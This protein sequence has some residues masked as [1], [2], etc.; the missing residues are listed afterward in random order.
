MTFA[1]TLGRAVRVEGVG[2]HMGARAS[3]ELR[4]H[5][6]PGIRFQRDGTT[7]SATLANVVDTRLA[8]TLGVGGVRVA[9]VEHLCAALVGAGI[10]AVEVAVD[11]PELPVLDGSALPWLEAIDGAGTADTDAPLSPFVV[12]QAVIV[13]RDGGWAR[14]DPAPAFDLDVT[15]EFGHPRIGAQ[16][17]TGRAAG[18]V[19]R[20]E[21]APART[22]GFLRDADALR[23]AG[24]ARGA[25]LE[26]TVVYDDHGVMNPGGLR[27][28][29]EAVRHKALDAV[30]DIALLGAPLLGKLTTYRAGHSLHRDLIEALLASP[31]R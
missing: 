7:I 31:L 24:L 2:L 15:V 23:A 26:N 1:R 17:F 4:P 22:F 3:V 28:P 5:A 12:S 8:T 25:S 14:V 21:I 13:S 19:F 6:G 16:R 30:G 29:D 27:W 20:T 10:D 11:G 18:D 9:M